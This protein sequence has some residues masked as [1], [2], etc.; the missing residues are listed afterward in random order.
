MEKV[1]ERRETRKKEKE[2]KKKDDE[3]KE[4]G[5]KESDREVGNQRRAKNLVPK[6]FYK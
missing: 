2:N 5:N 6:Q 3:N 1:E 4:S